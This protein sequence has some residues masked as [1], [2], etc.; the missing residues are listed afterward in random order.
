MLWVYSILDRIVG[1]NT[2]YCGKKA[3]HRTATAIGTLI[4]VDM[5]T[6]EVEQG[7]FS[8]DAPKPPEEVIETLKKVA[9]P[10]RTH[11]GAVKEDQIRKDPKNP[12]IFGNNNGNK[13]VIDDA[14]RMHD[15][16][17]NHASINHV[18]SSNDEVG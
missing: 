7:K 16:R 18:I 17:E 5:T 4:K 3:M 8:R 6:K 12:F 14:V 10:P 9:K 1:L 11:D 15:I 13:S 2:S